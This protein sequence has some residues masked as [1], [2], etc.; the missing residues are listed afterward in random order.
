MEEIFISFNYLVLHGR[1][2]HQKWRVKAKLREDRQEAAGPNEVWAMDFVYE[3]L[4]L[5]RK[6]RILT[7]VDPHSRYCLAVDPSFA[8]RGEDVV[9]IIC[10]GIFHPLSI[11]VRPNL[12]TE[13]E[14]N[15]IHG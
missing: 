15:E 9:Q 13:N 7:I 10:R 5:G 6:L 12:R 1:G 4:A 8:Y 2:E 3:Q 11:R 14:A